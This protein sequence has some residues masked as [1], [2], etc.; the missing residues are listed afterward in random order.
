MRLFKH[1]LWN[2]YFVEYSYYRS[3]SAE[4]PVVKY[5]KRF[6]VNPSPE[7]VRSLDFAHTE[8]DFNKRD[9]LIEILNIMYEVEDL[10]DRH[11][12]STYLEFIIDKEIKI[13]CQKVGIIL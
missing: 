2:L 1:S 9:V 5:F 13:L 11:Q 12:L 7:Y 10:K 8:G 4:L 3:S 6:P